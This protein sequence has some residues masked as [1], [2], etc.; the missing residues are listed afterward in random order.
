MSTTTQKSTRE[1]ISLLGPVI[2]ETRDET[3]LAMGKFDETSQMIAC[4]VDFHH[5]FWSKK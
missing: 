4:S 5:L 1:T 3:V 2:A